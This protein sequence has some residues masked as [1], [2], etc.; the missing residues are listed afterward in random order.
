MAATAAVVA[1][2]AAVEV[3]ATA[4]ATAAAADAAAAR[5]DKYGEGTCESQKM[6][7][8][9]CQQHSQIWYLRQV[10]LESDL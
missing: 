2:A 4:S 8:R 10:D 6:S 1:E 9:V 5:N 3:V 7:I